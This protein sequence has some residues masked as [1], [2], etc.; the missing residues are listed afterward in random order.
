[1]FF[2]FI[3]YISILRNFTGVSAAVVGISI[4][5]AK[6]VGDD[7]HHKT[8]CIVLSVWRLE[9]HVVHISSSTM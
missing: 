6:A 5:A 3:Y 4:A 7:Y 2:N 1:M 9:V 8:R